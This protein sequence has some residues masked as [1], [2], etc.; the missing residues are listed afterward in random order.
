MDSMD[1]IAAAWEGDGALPAL[2]L[3]DLANMVRTMV[4]YVN[5]RKCSALEKKLI[6]ANLSILLEQPEEGEKEN[7]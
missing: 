5:Q 1:E 2:R 3:L 6:A 4:A 7:A